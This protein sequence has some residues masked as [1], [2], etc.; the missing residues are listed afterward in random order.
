[1]HTAAF[2]GRVGCPMPFRELVGLELWE[3]PIS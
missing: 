2:G 1:M 3:F